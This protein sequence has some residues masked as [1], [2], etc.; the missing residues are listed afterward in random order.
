MNRFRIAFYFRFFCIS[1][2]GITGLLSAQIPGVESGRRVVYAE[3][4]ERSGIL[5][6]SELFRLVDDWNI[7][8][9]DDYVWQY[10]AGGRYVF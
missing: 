7:T 5:R 2:L 6:L 9:V 3:D 4:I 8:S 1:V 10:S